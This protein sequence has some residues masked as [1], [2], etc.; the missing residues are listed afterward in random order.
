M[1]WLWNCFRVYRVLQ[2]SVVARHGRADGSPTDAVARLVEAHQRALEAAGAGQQIG[3]RAR[4]RPAG[5][6]AGDGGAQAPLAV[7][8]VG[9]EAGAVCLDQES[10]DAIVFVFD[11]GPDD[12]D[13]GEIAGGDPHLFAVE[14]VFIAG[15]ARGGGHAAGI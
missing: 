3:G 7:N 1:G 12:G 15:L 2:R 8:L 5:K 4:A 10:A 9:A 14:N 11:L 6:A 13:V